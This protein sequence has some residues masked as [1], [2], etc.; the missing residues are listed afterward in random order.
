[1]MSKILQTAL[2]LLLLQVIALAQ[3]KTAPKYSARV[4][5]R[6]FCYAV[7]IRRRHAENQIAYPLLAESKPTW[8]WSQGVSFSEAD[9]HRSDDLDF[10]GTEGFT[11]RL[12]T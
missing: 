5:C 9:T 2:I 4:D 1:M 3:E 10:A 12:S 11:D 8:A 7:T 6:L